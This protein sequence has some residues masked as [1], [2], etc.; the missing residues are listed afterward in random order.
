M[1]F[2]QAE[3]AGFLN[4]N[5]ECVWEELRPA[6]HVVIDFKNGHVLERTLNGNVATL[7]CTA[8]AEVYD[9]LPGLVNLKTYKQAAQRALRNFQSLPQGPDRVASMAGRYRQSFNGAASLG[10]ASLKPVVF[11]SKL[12]V[13]YPIKLAAGLPPGVQVTAGGRVLLQPFDPTLPSREELDAARLQEDTLIVT[14]QLLPHALRLLAR[15]PL[16][17]PEQLTPALFLEVLHVDLEDP[18]LGLAPD[19]LGGRL[20]RH[21]P[22]SADGRL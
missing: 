3:L 6:P 10:L 5:F 19:Y 9:L 18:Y 7:F 13:E 22:L 2:S 11:A 1:L 8:E 16:C 20:G 15:T 21:G 14:S 4:E 17:T 12:A